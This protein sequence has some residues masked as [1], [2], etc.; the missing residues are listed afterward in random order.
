MASVDRHSHLPGLPAAER[1]SGLIST[2]ATTGADGS[3][4]VIYTIGTNI[5][6]SP[7]TINVTFPGVTTQTY[8]IPLQTA[9][10]SYYDFAPTGP[11]TTTAGVGLSYT[12]TARDIY[13]NAV[14]NN[15]NIVFTASDRLPQYS[16]Q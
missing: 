9:A 7:E 14:I 5:A 6:L 8:S 13:G 15:D 1:F 10:V 16:H 2:T 12:V 3:V 4:E 11:R